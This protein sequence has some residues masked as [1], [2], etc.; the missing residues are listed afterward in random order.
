MSKFLDNFGILSH[1]R[2]G[3][4]FLWET[5]NVNFD[6]RKPDWYL[7]VEGVEAF[8]AHCAPDQVSQFFGKDLDKFLLDYSC[9]YIMRDVRDTLVAAWYYWKA[10]AESNLDISKALK[11]KSFSQYIRGASI[12]E[13]L[14]Y[15]IDIN[16][17]WAKNYLDPIQYWIDFTKWSGYV[18]TIKFEDLKLKPKKVIKDFSDKFDL[19]TKNKEYALINK[20]V[21]NLPRKGIIGDWRNII[22]EG[23]RKYIYSRAGEVMTSFGY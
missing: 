9:V 21:G 22:N 16:S 19:E 7:K 1:R 15:N 5:L 11:G 13:T 20:L 6:I 14:S 8:K 17:L 18:H 3:T 4:H 10:G 23:D 2:S 12:E